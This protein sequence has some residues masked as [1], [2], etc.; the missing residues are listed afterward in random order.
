MNRSSAQPGNLE[1]DQE[2]VSGD[3]RS[4]AGV[5]SQNREENKFQQVRTEPAQP[6]GLYLSL[7]TAQAYSIMRNIPPQYRLLEKTYLKKCITRKKARVDNS[8]RHQRKSNITTKPRSKRQR[9]DTK[10]KGEYISSEYID[11]LAYMAPP[12]NTDEAAPQQFRGGGRGSR[13]TMA[14][15]PTRPSSDH[16]KNKASYGPTETLDEE[17]FSLN[18]G[19]SR[20]GYGQFEANGEKNHHDSLP[21]SD[22]K[23][24]LEPVVEDVSPKGKEVEILDPPKHIGSSH[25]P[26]HSP[27]EN[28]I[29]I[30]DNTANMN[31]MKLSPVPQQPRLKAEEEH[32]SE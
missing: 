32:F 27:V 23:I 12:E 9:G 3:I 18:K 11:Q 25:I 14:T 28:A 10:T 7:S 20:N 2:G 5:S 19:A 4:D 17:K 8:L 30:P 1:D 16:S 26:S 22:M 24:K 15:E 21:V 29:P 31:A 13:G 6:Q